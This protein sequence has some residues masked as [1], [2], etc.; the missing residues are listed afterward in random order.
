MKDDV[1]ARVILL[2]LLAAACKSPGDAE[3]TAGTTTEVAT[4]D[5][6][7]TPTTGGD[8]TTTDSTTSGTTSGT[9]GMTGEPTTGATDTGDTGDTGDTTGAEGGVR[10]PEPGPMMEP[11]GAGVVLAISRFF[12]GDTDRDG[13]PNKDDGWRQ[14]GYDLDLRISDAGSTD[15]CLPRQNANP[16]SVYPDGDDGIDNNF[17]KLLLP[18]L[19]SLSPDLGAQQ[20]DAVSSGEYTLLFDL[21][22]LGAGTDYNPLLTRHYVGAALKGAPKFDG[23]DAWPVD[24]ASLTNPADI[25]TPKL[26]F[27]DSYVTGNT[28]VGVAAPDAILT[29]RIADLDLRVRNAVITMDLDASHQFAPRGT[30]AGVLS[31]DELRDAFKEFAGAFDPGLCQGATIESFLTQVEQAADILLG[32][33][34]DPTK[35]CDAISIGIGFEAAGVK[36]GA[37]AAGVPEQDFCP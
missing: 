15:L 4:T 16:G 21:Q 27:A 8:A 18:S 33:T 19:L 12:L 35:Q 2:S 36:L 37:I 24:P 31:V 26:A 10:P 5:T 32:A 1:V 11:D 9:G 30:L 6:G 7:S 23:S 28:W 29:L 13:T 25:L 14:Y 20:N 22:Q 3:T 34:Q 17:G